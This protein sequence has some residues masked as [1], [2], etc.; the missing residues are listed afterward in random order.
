MNKKKI[1]P[2]VVAAVVMIVVA[3]VVWLTGRGP[4]DACASALP[5]QLTLVGRVNPMQVA[6]SGQFDAE[7]LPKLQGVDL[8]SDAY[9]FGSQGYFGAVLPLSDADDFQQMLETDGCSVQKQR[10]LRWTV[11]HES[12]LLCMD[13]D[14]AMLMGPAT[15]GE[16][17]ALRNTLAQC[18]KQKPA[19]SGMQ[20]PEYRLLADAAEPAVLVGSLGLIPEEYTEKLRQM[21]PKGVTPAD[22][23]FLST[24]SLSADSLV[25][26]MTLDSENPKAMQFLGDLDE[27]LQPIQG[28]LVG[29]SPADA[30]LQL[31][32]GLKGE[33]WLELL[34][35]NPETRTK[36]L[37]ANMGMDLDMMV[38]AIDG[39]V[40]YV[41]PR[42]SESKPKGIVRAT[43]TNSDFMKN[44]SD[45]NGG[46]SERFGLYFVPARNDGYLA[47]WDD[48][49]FYFG[50]REGV[51]YA[52][53]DEGLTLGEGR[54]DIAASEDMKSCCVY[55]TVD[56]SSMQQLMQMLPAVLPGSVTDY[57]S[58]TQRVELTAPRA[59]HWTLRMVQSP[60]T[61]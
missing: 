26:Q 8:Q 53:N 12:F 39:D 32:A 11:W 48:L 1:I 31:T 56:L 60:K 17:D 25:M 42:W 6:Q 18:M 34:R 54:L 49:A 10:G 43:L 47:K 44:V 33:K 37:A 4:A 16:L 59:Q 9:V 28:N 38:K 7:T 2:L 58:H 15:G 24:L 13:D 22:I 3:L 57:L 50:V 20:T 41:M 55:A 30:F 5:N 52:A 14:K 36:L 27:A 61:N 46:A 23:R 51:L 40:S 29:L 19:Q 45:W 21:L 35:K